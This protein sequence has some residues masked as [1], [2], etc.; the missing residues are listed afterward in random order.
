MPLI[1]RDP[2]IFALGQHLGAIFDI[3]HGGMEDLHAL[4]IEARRGLTAG[5]RAGV[6]HDYQIMRATRYFSA[7]DDVRVHELNKLFVFDIGQVV[8][9]RFKKFDAALKSCNQ[10]TAQVRDF[11]SQVQLC[12]VDAPSNLEAGY[13]LDPLEK[14]IIWAGIVCPNNEG[15][16]WQVE[17]KEAKTI[18]TVTDIFD[19]SDVQETGTTFKPK[20]TGI[21]IPITRDSNGVQ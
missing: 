10:S 12:G 17:L 14:E 19:Q 18:N 21:V 6:V 20:K 13:I 2:A 15:F 3:L 9:L 7:F 11:R 8:A 16:Y 1:D 4:P 5:T